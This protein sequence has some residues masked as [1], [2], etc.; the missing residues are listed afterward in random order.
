LS[1]TSAV[2][3][4]LTG[5]NVRVLAVSPGATATDFF[6]LAGAKPSGELAP[7]SDVVSTT[8]KALDAKNTRPS[9]VVG[10]KNA[11]MSSLT[12]FFPKKAVVQ[13]AGGMFLPKKSGIGLSPVL[14]VLDT[15]Q[16]PPRIISRAGSFCLSSEHAKTSLPH[17]PMIFCAH[18]DIA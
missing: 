18:S 2:W 1:F 7:V 14:T 15:S 5:T 4:E 12:S 16:H 13:V 6:T 17:F 9:V 3:G 10:R 8:F 11:V